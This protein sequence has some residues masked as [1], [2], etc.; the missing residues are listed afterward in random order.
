MSSQWPVVVSFP[1]DRSTSRPR[2]RGGLRLRRAAFEVFDVAEPELLEIRKVEAADGA[3]H[4]AERIRALV[5]V[6]GRIRQFAGPNGV[7][8]DHACPWHGAIL[9]LAWTQSSGSSACSSGSSW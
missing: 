2:Q 6:L 5:T 7:E 8:D 9:F 4:V 3:G 1:F